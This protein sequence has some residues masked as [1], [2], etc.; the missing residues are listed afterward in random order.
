MEQ[1]EHVHAGFAGG[2]N[3]EGRASAGRDRRYPTGE[4]VVVE[5]NVAVLQVSPPHAFHLEDRKSTRL[6]S[7]HLGIS[8]AVFCLKKKKGC[9]AR[10]REATRTLARIRQSSAPRTRADDRNGT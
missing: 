5:Q 6:N 8:Y 4:V 9:I 3:R 2:G 7:S 10:L 1:F